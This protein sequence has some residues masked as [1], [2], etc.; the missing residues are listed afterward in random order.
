MV[1]RGWTVGVDFG[2]TNV[3]V[4]LVNAAGRVLRRASLVSQEVSEPVRFAESVS[5]VVEGLSR[6]AGLRTAQLRGVGVGVP[7]VVDVPRGVAHSLVNIPGWREVPLRRWLERRLRCPC[8][9]DN[10]V[11]AFTL[12]EWRFGAGRGARVLVGATLGTG[13]GGGLLFNG[14][15]FRGVGGAAGEIG[16]TVIN[17]RGP[18]CGCGARG[19][20]EAH[21]G[22]AAILS[23]ARRA[24]RR[25]PG[26]LRAAARRARGRLTPALVSAASQE[27]D[28]AARAV[29]NEVGRWLGIGLA[30]VVNII[31]PDRLVLG[32]GVANA[33]RFFYPTLIRTLRA[34]AL[35][36]PA[37]QV[38]V[39]RARLGLDAGMIGAA[40]LAWEHTA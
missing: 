39:V 34:Q 33:W 12:G 13:V 20:L 4:G 35:G 24:I 37:R 38:R 31:N 16:H 25:S 11:N 15:L 40:V 30:N 10:D 29:W 27:G 21:V 22:T 17:P 18:R 26:P 5:R 36:V 14:A 8:S 9:V 19:C 3:K 7:G 1:A 28:E 23:A 2:G 32:G 6:A